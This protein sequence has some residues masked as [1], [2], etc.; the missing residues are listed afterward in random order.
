MEIITK[1]MVIDSGKTLKDY[2][3]KMGLYI[4]N[5]SGIEGSQNCIYLPDKT[6]FNWKSRTGVRVN[7]KNEAK[8]LI[9]QNTRFNVVDNYSSDSTREFSIVID[10]EEDLEAVVEA[11]KLIDGNAS[12]IDISENLPE[13][14]LL[15]RDDL[16]NGIKNVLRSIPVVVGTE[17]SAVTVKFQELFI[18]GINVEEEA[19][20]IYNASADWAKQTSY[21]CEDS[22]D[23]TWHYYLET[24]DE[25]IGETQRLVMFEAQNGNK[26]SVSATIS[27]KY[28]IEKEELNIP[29]NWKG[30]PR[31]KFI[32][33]FKPLVANSEFT[34]K[35]N[36]TDSSSKILELYKNGENKRIM[37]MSG[38]QDMSL[39]VF[40]N[41]DF[42]KA[43][44]AY[45]DLPENEKVYRSQPHMNLTFEQV[46]NVICVAT[47][48]K[49]YMEMMK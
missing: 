38:K 9:E 11:L 37:G 7:C 1:S 40:F 22:G 4:S 5:V 27:F 24:I 39:N 6:S 49:Q 20:K 30:D 42:Y 16:E 14:I 18:C 45:I 28:Q 8:I 46:W 15:R 25:C 43:I 2:L 19:Y 17:E 41:P 26:K 13:C 33:V 31:T 34:F 23:G 21:L 29:N 44:N 48:K 3:E 35:L 12:S 36:T 47:G 10:N 32:N